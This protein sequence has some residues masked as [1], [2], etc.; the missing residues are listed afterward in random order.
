MKQQQTLLEFLDSLRP[1]D[2]DRAIGMLFGWIPRAADGTLVQR[3]TV[4]IS[5][6][7]SPEELKAR[8]AAATGY[9][10]LSVEAIAGQMIFERDNWLAVSA[11]IQPYRDFLDA[12]GR[13][14]KDKY[15]ELTDIGR[16]LID[17]DSGLELVVPDAPLLYPDFLLRDAKGLLG[18]E[19]TRL[20]DPAA[21]QA[22]NYLRE[23]VS[24][25][26]ELLLREQPQLYGSV[27]VFIDDSQPVIAERFFRNGKF[28]PVERE[29]ITRE[30]A[31]YVVSVING[32]PAE[33]P[34][35]IAEVSY[36]PNPEPRLDVNLGE[37]YISKG[38]FETL[39]QKRIDAK[40][41]RYATY[42]EASPIDRC[43]LLLVVDGV[44]SY[45]G[46]DLKTVVFPKIATSNYSF[47]VLLEAISHQVYSI[48]TQP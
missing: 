23:F 7:G 18:I 10:H 36:L 34:A 46:F 22:L 48:Y 15:E 16:Y 26:H 44:S 14:T 33:K 28:S 47:I 45:S 37:T 9:D 30:I 29:T 21:K 13:A 1:A 3:T 32:Q 24:A 42:I 8:I 6:P 40:E 4:K 25:A 31:A 17:S 38:E 43:G 5:N 27:N 20:I 19:H 2:R 35:Y 39:L 12:Q 41:A 11:L